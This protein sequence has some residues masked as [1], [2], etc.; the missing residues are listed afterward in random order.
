[1]SQP[2]EE[3]RDQFIKKLVHKLNKVCLY[4]EENGHTF[5]GKED[6]FLG[7]KW[8]IE[9]FIGE[10]H[11]ICNRPYC[12]N[13]FGMDALCLECR[14]TI[15]KYEQRYD[16]HFVISQFEII[17]RFKILEEEIVKLKTIIE[18]IKGSIPKNVS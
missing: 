12:Y 13:N 15:K 8:S 7:T 6:P 9:N 4:S 10:E 2:I 11:L 17:Q 1:M 3:Y 5:W 16:N 18:E 14:Q